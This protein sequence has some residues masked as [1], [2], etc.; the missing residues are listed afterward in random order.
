MA[1]LLQTTAEDGSDRR[2]FING[3][4]VTLERFEQKRTGR[5]DSFLT[6]K[7]NGRWHHRCS[8]HG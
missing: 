4:R 3:Q 6:R 8:A 5:L 1:D 2:F 7:V